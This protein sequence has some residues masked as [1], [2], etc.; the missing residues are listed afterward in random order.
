MIAKREKKINGDVK[1]IPRDSRS[2]VYWVTTYQKYLS[3]GYIERRVTCKH[4]MITRN[5]RMQPKIVIRN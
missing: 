2:F 3:I 5:Q 1:K 4:L